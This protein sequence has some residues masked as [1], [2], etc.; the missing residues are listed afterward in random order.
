MAE[1][2]ECGRPV[3]WAENCHGRPV[4]LDPHP[5]G[6]VVLDRHG[7]TGPMAGQ[8]GRPDYTRRYVRHNC[9]AGRG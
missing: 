1:C 9:E 5:A 3:V 4:P 6:G 8:E 7:R 2:R